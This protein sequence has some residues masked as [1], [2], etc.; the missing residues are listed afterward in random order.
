MEEAEID[1]LQQLLTQDGF[2]SVSQDVFDEITQLLATI[3]NAP[4][5]GLAFIDGDE[6]THVAKIGI[7]LTTMPLKE[8]VCQFTVKQ[9]T[10]ME[11]PDTLKDDRVNELDAIKHGGIRF[12]AGISLC[13]ATTE[14]DG[15]IY[16]ADYKPRKLNAVQRKALGLVAR[17]L[18]GFINTRE[19]NRELVG[20]LQKIID[21]RLSETRRELVSKEVAFDFLYNSLLRSGGVI[22]YDPK[23]NIL[24]VNGL[25]CRMV[26]YSREELVG[27]HR[28]MLLFDEDNNEDTKNSIRK[29]VLA[30]KSLFRRVKLR[31]KSGDPVYLQCSYNPIVDKDRQVIRVIKVAHN[32][33]EEIKNKEALEQAKRLTDQ[34]NVQKDHFI[35]NISHELRTPINAILGFTNILLEEEENAERHEMLRAVLSAGNSLLHVVSDILDLSK[36]ESGLFQIDKKPFDLKILVHSVIAML[37]HRL[38]DRNI[39]LEAKFDKGLPPVILSDENRLKQIL[40]NLLGNAIK[41]TKK[42]RISVSVK[43]EEPM[44]VFR[45]KDTGIG[46]AE[47]KLDTIFDR[48]T[49]AESDTTR[50]YGGSGLGLNIVQQLVEKL[51]GEIS[52][53]SQ[54]N[55]GSVFTFTLPL[56]AGEAAETPEHTGGLLPTKL[57]AAKI[58]LCEDNPLNQKLVK[59]LFAGTPYELDIADNGKEGIARLSKKKYD[60]VLMDIQMPVMDGMQATHEIVNNL[61]L[62]TPIIALTAHSL[63]KEKKEC[64]EIGMCDYVT[65]P[66]SKSLLFNKIEEWLLHSKAGQKCTPD[67]Q[68]GFSLQQLD[69]FSNGDAA[70]KKEMLH[71][72][73]EQAK[74][75]QKSF[76]ELVEKEDFEAIAAL[77]HKLKTSFGIISADLKILEKIEKKA[78]KPVSIK[79]IKK[80]IMRFNEQLEELVT[81]ISTLKTEE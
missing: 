50:K 74:D 72:F 29:D 66:F 24:A 62:S 53:T 30:G 65:K 71:L 38:K 52:V 5:A 77:A 12:Y 3:C 26:G 81:Q 75:A 57:S 7:E 78:K 16:V 33:T 11:V 49:Q 69:E 17:H 27:A 2:L 51:G 25:F 58:L 76:P 32:I 59:S 63:I 37:Q 9:Q 23:G 42:G 18:T 79:K 4:L 21:E 20:E 55:K 41:F 1:R 48:F 35:A 56:E 22:E 47:D 36:L 40:I 45:I 64:L 39:R 60:L 44:L 70:F 73:L 31:T 15:V 67:V 68:A 80:E 8:T 19:R 34:L 43:S 14:A 28:D 54:P 61:K 6:Y 10:I 13:E 46:I